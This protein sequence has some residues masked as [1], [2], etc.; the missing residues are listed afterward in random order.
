MSNGSI[1]ND[2]SIYVSG[3]DDNTPDSDATRTYC[4]ASISNLA[5]NDIIP[6]HDNRYVF[7]LC[8]E[9][10]GYIDNANN[11]E[12]FQLREL[13]R[14]IYELIVNYRMET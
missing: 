9:I 12:K 2:F 4:N 5:T 10:L 6:I 7:C 13:A 1:D 8:G 3:I 11:E 14:S